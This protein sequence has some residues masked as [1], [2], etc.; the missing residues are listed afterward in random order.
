[1]DSASV[2]KLPLITGE[3]AEDFAV[4]LAITALSLAGFEGGHFVETA[5]PT[6]GA[7]GPFAT[8]TLSSL[9]FSLLPALTAAPP[10]TKQ[11][12]ERWWRH[13]GCLCIL[14]SG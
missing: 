13:C 1:M 14:S 9:V 12:T 10:L 5:S 4:E 3:Q 6:F 11:K 8:G 2:G 7:G